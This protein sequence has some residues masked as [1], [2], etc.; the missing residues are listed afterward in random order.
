[1]NQFSKFTLFHAAEFS[2]SRSMLQRDFFHLWLN[3]LVVFLDQINEAFHCVGFGDVELDRRLTNVGCF[4]TPP[5]FGVPRSRGSVCPP[6]EPPEG[7]TPN[8]DR[9]NAELQT[10]RLTS[11]RSLTWCLA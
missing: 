6:P 9:V 11:A 3:P 1:M 7:G 10:M 2:A 5:P 4:L 8:P